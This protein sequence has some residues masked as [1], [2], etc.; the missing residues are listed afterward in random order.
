MINV[1]KLFFESKLGIL[2]SQL[3]WHIIKDN[4]FARKDKTVLDWQVS[5][6]ADSHFFMFNKRTRFLA[7]LQVPAIYSKKA[8]SGWIDEVTNPYLTISLTKLDIHT[9]MHMPVVFFKTRVS[10]GILLTSVNI[11][12]M[13]EKAQRI[14]SG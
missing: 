9:F 13:Y 7:N 10:M 11:A 1:A 4:F 3:F 6:A 12:R 2:L 8:A 5:L 14:N